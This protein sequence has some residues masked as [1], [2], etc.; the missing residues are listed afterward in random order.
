MYIAWTTCPYVVRDG[1]VNPD[2]L[3]LTGV[4]AINGLSQAVLYSAI[5]YALSSSTVYSQ[6]LVRLIDF[7]F[8]DEPTRMY[9][10]MNYGQLIRGPGPDGTV[11]TWTGILDLRGLVKVVN[12]IHIIK[13]RNSPDWTPARDRLMNDWMSQYAKWLTGSDLGKETASRLKYVTILPSGFYGTPDNLT[14]IMYL[15]TSRRLL[16]PR[17]SLVIVTERL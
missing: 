3:T 2:V 9:P 10:N 17:Y 5:A 7:F 16:R 13:G 14:V 1:R 15:T 4:K 8:L 6:N 11:G 12:S